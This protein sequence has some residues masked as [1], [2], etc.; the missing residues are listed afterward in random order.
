MINLN[1]LKVIIALLFLMSLLSCDSSFDK[2]DK[3]WAC[4]FGKS[5]RYYLLIYYNYK[6]NEERKINVISQ[7]QPTEGEETYGECTHKIFIQ[8]TNKSFTINTGED[9]VIIDRHDHDFP[10][11]LGTIRYGCCGGPDIVNFYTENGKYLGSL[12]GFKL[13]ERANTENII[14]RQFDMKNIIS[15]RKKI[16]IIV[17]KEDNSNDY[18][19]VVLDNSN[20]IIVIP[21]V[22]PISEKEKE[23]CD[24]WHIDDF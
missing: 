9:V 21:L 24:Y 2:I 18:Q 19:V 20:N 4:D 8:P 1:A 12:E 3:E 13:L 23:K 10:V 15:I 17:E 11:I 5:K 7:C 6:T 22:L 14:I 16:Y